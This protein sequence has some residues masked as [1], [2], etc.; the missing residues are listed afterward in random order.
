MLDQTTE[1]LM[2]TRSFIQLLSMKT[3]MQFQF[4][5]LMG[6]QLV[7]GTKKDKLLQK[8]HKSFSKQTAFRYYYNAK[9]Q[10]ITGM[11]LP[12]EMSQ[13][14]HMKI[15]QKNIERFRNLKKVK[16]QVGRLLLQSNLEFLPGLRD[17]L[18]ILSRSNLLMT[19]KKLNQTK[20]QLCTNNQKKNN[21]QMRKQDKNNNERH[22]NVNNSKL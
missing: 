17:G 5:L 21:N 13:C 15:Y 8:C 6:L 14:L 16:F 9:E 11:Q 3:W 10:L 19:L 12:K 18:K 22:L 1:E 20:N 2:E 7:L 4:L